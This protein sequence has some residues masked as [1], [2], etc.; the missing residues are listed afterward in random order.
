MT[1]RLPSVIYCC[2]LTFSASAQTP[3][4]P[5]LA[6]SVTH[7]HITP[8]A[9]PLRS[10]AEL[11]TAATLLLHLWPPPSFS[12]FDSAKSTAPPSNQIR[13]DS[14][15]FD[16]S[17]N[18]TNVSCGLKFLFPKPNQPW[19]RR[20]SFENCP[21]PHTLPFPAV[22]YLS[23]A[24]LSLPYALVRLSP[25]QVLPPPICPAVTQT[26]I[27]GKHG[28]ARELAAS[29]F[30]PTAVRAARILILQLRR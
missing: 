4:S 3:A 13:T 5:N 2:S 27:P 20:G 10:T 8:F 1:R 30:V 7:H 26:Q 6:A 23:F 14:H 19:S 11:S 18:T 9:Q 24:L 17:S 22:K 15:P 21:R 25:P 29:R 16:P 12:T 28:G